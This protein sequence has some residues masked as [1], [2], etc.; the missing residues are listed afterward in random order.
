MNRNE[1]IVEEW[2]NCW[3]TKQF[4]NDMTPKDYSSWR[5]FRDYWLKF[6]E[7]SI[8]EAFKDYLR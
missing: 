5:K 1:Q 8:N 3:I 2:I 7:K 6:P 4:P